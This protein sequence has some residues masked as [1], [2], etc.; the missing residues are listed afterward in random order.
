MC[1]IRIAFAVGLSAQLVC[2][3]LYPREVAPG[4][5]SLASIVQGYF[6]EVVTPIFFGQDA[7]AG[8]VTAHFGWLAGVILFLPFA[9]ALCFAVRRGRPVVRLASIALVLLSVVIWVAGY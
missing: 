1:P 3:L 6:I 4:S 7:T 5:P 2:T 9:A 8:A